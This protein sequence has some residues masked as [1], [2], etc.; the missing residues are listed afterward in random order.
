MKFFRIFDPFGTFVKMKCIAWFFDSVPFA[1]TIL[2]WITTANVADMW[3][4]HWNSRFIY[5]QI[6]I[7]TLFNVH[8]CHA[9]TIQLPSPSIVHVVNGV[10]APWLKQKQRK[11]AARTQ[12]YVKTKILIINFYKLLDVY[13]NEH[14][15]RFK[16]KRKIWTRIRG[17]DFVKTQVYYLL[18]FRYYS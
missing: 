14:G 9:N 12:K 5:H 17:R 11:I 2:Q 6:Y 8:V 10:L 18:S 15:T 3:A 1:A 4:P 13:M 7:K 16:K